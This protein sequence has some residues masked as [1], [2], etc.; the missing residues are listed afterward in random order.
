M[1]VRG[2]LEVA[3]DGLSAAARD[4]NAPPNPACDGEVNAFRQL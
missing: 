2:D 3:A 4:Q 1:C